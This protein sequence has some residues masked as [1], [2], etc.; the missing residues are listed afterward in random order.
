M[1][2]GR[3][4]LLVLSCLLGGAPS[5]GQTGSPATSARPPEPGAASSDVTCAGNAV[6]WAGSGPEVQVLRRGT[7]DQRSPLAPQAE[8]L[9]ATVLEVSI[10]GKPA[11]TYG[12]SFHEMRRAGPPQELEKEFGAAIQWEGDL[13]G[14]PHEILLIGDDGTEVVAR[15]RFV[16]CVARPKARPTRE[17]TARSRPAEASP[18]AKPKP[19][20]VAVP[21][22]A[23]Q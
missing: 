10:R 19:P 15:L 2:G 13:A 5:L 4:F 22:G 16:K 7:I 6:Y 8:A 1:R 12:P 3:N 18:A 11:A 9:L 17:P 21:R 23:I 20:P 14:L